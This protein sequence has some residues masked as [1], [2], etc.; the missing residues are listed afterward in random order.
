MRRPRIRCNPKV[1]TAFAVSL[2][3]AG[4]AHADPL[5]RVSIDWRAPA[6]CPDRAALEAAIRRDLAG[7]QATAQHLGADAAVE[8]DRSGIWRAVVT[9]Q[10]GASK[11]VRRLEARS[12]DEL[13]QASSLIVAMVI[14]PD[15]AV[16]NRQTMAS[17]DESGAPAPS[18]ARAASSVVAATNEPK[19]APEGVTSKPAGRVSV[20]PS[21][22]WGT[23]SGWVAIDGGSLPS[24][25]VVY[26]GAVGLSY[27]RWRAETSLGFWVPQDKTDERFGTPGPGGRFSVLAGGLRLCAELWQR[28]ALGLGPCV[29]VEVER[30]S[31]AGN[32]QLAVADVTR[33]WSASAL[34][35]LLATLQ[36]TSRL[37]FRLDLQAAA[38]SARPQFGFS[39]YGEQIALF[40]PDRLLWRA[41]AGAELRFH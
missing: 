32:A 13:V 31:A 1:P 28:G 9:L 34:L 6:D 38:A 33:L 26:G 22:P 25:A 19:T 14:D 40:Q 11:S 8:L 5:S 7:S 35:S 18:D 4:L 2:V 16:A 37:G 27:G 3:I 29:G 36:A 30:W 39:Q 15:V 41:G 20:A 21:G 12:C 23:V 24:A 10:N 17:R